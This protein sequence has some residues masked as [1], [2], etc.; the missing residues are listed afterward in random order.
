MD[1]DEFVEAFF[2][3]LGVDHKWCL[4]QAAYFALHGGLEDG[5]AI[6]LRGPGWEI[7]SRG[8][9]DKVQDIMRFDTRINIHKHEFSKMAPHLRELWEKYH[10]N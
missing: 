3:K 10:G 4:N 9:H 6:L 2:E 5:K 8:S 7:E 1:K